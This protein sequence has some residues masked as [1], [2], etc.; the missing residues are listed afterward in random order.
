[1]NKV[2]IIGNGT[3]G[4]ALLKA[5]W[6]QAHSATMASRSQSDNVQVLNIADAHAVDVFFK[7]AGL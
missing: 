7:D 1:M 4:K 5:D 3:L 2:L 6:L